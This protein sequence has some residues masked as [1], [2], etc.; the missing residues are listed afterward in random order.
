MDDEHR[1]KFYGNAV[2]AFEHLKATNALGE[3]EQIDEENVEAFL[4]WLADMDAIE[5][6]RYLEI[7]RERLAIIDEFEQRVGANEY[8]KVLQK[9]IFDHLWLLDPAWERATE[10]S[11]MEKQ[12]QNAIDRVRIRNKEEVRP[13]IRYRRI[14]GAHVIIEL[15][16]PSV[17]VRKT[18]IEDQV[19]DYISAVKQK[20]NQDSEM[21]RFPVEAICLLEKP[22][23]GWHNPEVRRRD[24]ESLRGYGIPSD[25]VHPTDK[26]CSLCLCEIYQGKSAA[27]RT[28]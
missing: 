18:E 17:S 22:P 5:A 13:D 9:Y 14:S 15:K 25:D 26:S 8:E 28:Q 1:H 11:D 2:L 27:G 19:N 12:I 24:E 16:R 3:L 23:V 4:A 10:Y 6:A 20:I 7:V 21:A